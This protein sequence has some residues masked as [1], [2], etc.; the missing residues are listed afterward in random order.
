[1]FVESGVGGG[2]GDGSIYDGSCVI[3][4]SESFAGG[5]RVAAG[6]DVG[7]GGCFVGVSPL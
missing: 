2:D 5:G 3:H 7:G 6:F 1:M 4:R